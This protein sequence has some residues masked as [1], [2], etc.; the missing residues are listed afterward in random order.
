MKK[1]GDETV[2]RFSRRF[3][4]FYYNMPKGIQPPKAAAKLCYATTL[5]P[6]VSFLLM[7]RRSKSFQQMFSD[8][9]EVEDNL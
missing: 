9:Q 4:S 7:E 3:S 8:A 6:D 1:Q 2:S 5:H